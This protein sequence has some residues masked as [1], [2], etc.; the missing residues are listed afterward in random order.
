M[1]FV[2]SVDPW[3][4]VKQKIASIPSSN[5]LGEPRVAQQT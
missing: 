1:S 2:D 4:S 5:S 3:L